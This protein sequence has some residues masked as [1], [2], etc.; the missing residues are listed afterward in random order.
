MSQAEKSVKDSGSVQVLSSVLRRL[1]SASILMS[2]SQESTQ[3]P[4]SAPLSQK[5]CKT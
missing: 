2:Y 4:I 1:L 3:S 5:G